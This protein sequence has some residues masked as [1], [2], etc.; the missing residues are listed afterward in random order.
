MQTVV[1]EL[2][3]KGKAARKSAR[4][5]AKTTGKAKDQALLNVADGLKSRQEDILEANERDIEAGRDKGLAEYYLDR[6]MLNPERLSG[7]ADDV[8]SVARPARPC[9]RDNGDARR[10]QRPAG[11]PPPGAAGR[12]RG[13][14]REQGRTS[15][16][17][18]RRCA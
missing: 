1:D 12:G 2:A 17:T 18:Y 4:Q 14:L 5:L 6:M 7:I 15:R 3:A 10:A 11:G 13:Y 8:R 16:W 9:G